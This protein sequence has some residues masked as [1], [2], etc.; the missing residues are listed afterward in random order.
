VRSH[1]FQ[2]EEAS[3]ERGL[4]SDGILWQPSDL[5]LSNHVGRLD[6]LKS[7]PRRVKG[8]ESLTGPEPALHGSVILFDDVV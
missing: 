7:S 1:R 5:S 4:P 3:N 2:P 6:T 8:P